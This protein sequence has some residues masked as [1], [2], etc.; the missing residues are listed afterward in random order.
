MEGVPLLVAV[1][2]GACLEHRSRFTDHSHMVPVPHGDDN[3]TLTSAGAT[4][5]FDG[6]ADRPGAL[7]TG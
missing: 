1:D 6:P 4:A 2:P 5:I 7:A 3:S